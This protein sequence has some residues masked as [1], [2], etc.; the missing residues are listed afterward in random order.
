MFLV[1][2]L[3]GLSIVGACCILVEVALAVRK[4]L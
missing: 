2:A 4:R 1:V 3:I